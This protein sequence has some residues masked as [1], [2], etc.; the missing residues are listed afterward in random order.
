MKVHLQT[1]GCRANQYDTEAVRAMV[2]AAGHQI[3]VDVAEADVAVINSCAVTM[4]AEADL[5]QRVRRVARANPG[6]RTVV[7]GCASAM[8]DSRKTIAALPSVQ[9]VIAGADMVRIASALDLGADPASSLPIAQRGARALLRVQDGC[10]ERCT[11]CATRI[12]R[13]V[14]R[15]R[16]PAVLI[17]EARELAMR[18][19]EIVLTGVHI[20]TY[21]ADVESSL[22]ELV[23]RL[24]WEV[25]DVRFR[26]S[27]VEATEVDDKLAD[28]LASDARRVAPYLH[29]PLQSGSDRILRRMGRHW[30]SAARYVA[31]VERL[32]ARMPVF[33]LGA[34]IIAGFPG[35][36][37]DDHESTL[38]LVNSLPFSSLHVFPYSVRPG[39]AAVHMAEH[40]RQDV[41]V[42]RAAELRALA[43]YK[44]RQYETGRVGGEADVV[45]TE[46][47]PKRRGV[48]EDHLTVAVTDVAYPRGSR[49]RARLEAG[50]TGL[51]AR[52]LDL[53]TRGPGTRNQAP[54]PGD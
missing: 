1:I 7:M 23:E 5:R 52:S 10:D 29:A 20:G 50:E 31:A 48:T 37:E 15:S 46:G 41:I 25:P 54:G 35:E 2:L 28:M 9:H 40:V 32:V 13:G 42:R 6:L 27:S 34:D 19:P 44:A 14:N 3:T 53:G 36:T 51:L 17:G 43:S 4:E 16:T 22:G 24:V 21:G 12:A 47:G 33:G 30:Y 39:T 8:P 45:V 11:F 26:L 18:H 49:F 38:A